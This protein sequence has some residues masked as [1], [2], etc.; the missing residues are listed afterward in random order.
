MHLLF[1]ARVRGK[2]HYTAVADEKTQ[3]IKNMVAKQKP[4]RPKP[5]KR[6]V[7]VLLN[8]GQCIGLLKLLGDYNLRF[9][10]V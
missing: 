7:H 4:K 2:L 6:K 8:T 10:Y 9:Q 3:H 5:I 1:Y